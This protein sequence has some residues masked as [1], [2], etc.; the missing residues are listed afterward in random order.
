LTVSAPDYAPR[1]YALYA[2]E[3]VDRAGIFARGIEGLSLL[4]GSKKAQ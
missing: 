2:G 4:L 1:S 3:A